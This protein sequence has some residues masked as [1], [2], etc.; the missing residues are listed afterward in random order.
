MKTFI[1]K[2][3]FYYNQSDLK[4]E[5]WNIQNPNVLKTFN[6]IS[7]ECQTLDKIIGT[8]SYRG[9]LS[10][11]SKVFIIN[12][13]QKNDLIK[14]DPNFQKL[15]KPHLSGKEVQRYRIDSNNH[16]IL[17]IKKGTDINQ[18]PAILEY[19]KPF[20]NQLENCCDKG[21]WYSLRACTYYN[22]FEKPKIIFGYTA[23]GPRFTFDKERFI[24]NNSNY[25]IPIYEL[26]LIGILDSKL[27]WFFVKN[28]RTYL[29]GDYSLY[30]H[31]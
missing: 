19:L 25:F 21:E 6:R 5:S 22:E 28:T 14:K 18:F 12:E 30:G 31:I 29:N 8:E 10:G 1:D 9:I 15:I 13:K 20:K 27:G 3:S 23:V 2:N 11:L 24:V 26:Q 16:Y 4:P 17:L 7:N